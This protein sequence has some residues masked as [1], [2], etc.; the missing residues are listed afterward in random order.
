MNPLAV[1]GIVLPLIEK[2]PTIEQGIMG[3][4]KAIHG[5]VQGGINPS[6]VAGAVEQSLPQITASI[7]ANTPHAQPTASGDTAQV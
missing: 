2:L 1:L 6:E 7:L 5:M 4:V 3:L